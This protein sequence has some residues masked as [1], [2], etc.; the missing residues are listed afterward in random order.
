MLKHFSAAVL[1]VLVVSEMVTCAAEADSCARPGATVT[2][3]TEQKKATVQ[4]TGVVIPTMAGQPRILNVAG[5]VHVVIQNDSSSVQIAN[6]AFQELE[7]PTYDVYVNQKL[8]GLRSREAL[9]TGLQVT[10]PIGFS[11]NQLPII[12]RLKESI[13]AFTSLYGASTAPDAAMANRAMSGITMGCDVA[14]SEINHTRSSYIILVPENRPLRRVPLFTARSRS[15][16]ER[17]MRLRWNDVVR[18]RRILNNQIKDQA[19]RIS[20]I[21]ALTPVKLSISS[22]GG[23]TDGSHIIEC[24]LTNLS[25]SPIGG[26][27]ELICPAGWGTVSKPSSSSFAAVGTNGIARAR[28]R[29]QSTSKSA[30]LHDVTLKANVRTGGVVFELKSKVQ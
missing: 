10:T 28:F 30:S 17:N 8:I 24:S 27:F 14:A 6:V 15:E 18:R 7:H 21:I 20:A 22:T 4:G 9:T 13:A 19:V 3:M 23:Q 29:A 11:I 2:V 16:V 1:A 26:E 12:E 25:V 5:E